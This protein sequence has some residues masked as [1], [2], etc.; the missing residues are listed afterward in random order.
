MK[1]EKIGMIASPNKKEELLVGGKPNESDTS[2][3][4]KK[5]NSM[6]ELWGNDND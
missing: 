1:D 6:G 5:E 2:S 4:K 3:E